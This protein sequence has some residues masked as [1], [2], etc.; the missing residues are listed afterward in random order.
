MDT[1]LKKIAAQWFLIPQELEHNLLPS[2]YLPIAQMLE[3]PLPL[4]N[5]APVTTNQPLQFFSPDVPDI[6]DEALVLHVRRLQIPDTKTINK[7]LASSRQSWLDGKRWLN[8]FQG[9]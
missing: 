2:P 6:S 8:L 4:Q 3:S 1:T 9:T 5:A 7:L